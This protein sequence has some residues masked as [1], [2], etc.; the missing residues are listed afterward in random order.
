MCMI[1]QKHGSLHRIAI[2]YPTYFL[3]RRSGSNSVMSITFKH[4]RPLIFVAVI[5]FAT[6][7]FSALITPVKGEDPWSLEGQ[8]RLASE[9]ATI[10]TPSGTIIFAEIADTPAKRAH[11]LM[12]RSTLA[13]DHGMLFVFPRSAYWTFWMKNTYIALDILWIDHDGYIVHLEP[14]VPICTRQDEGCPRYHPRKQSRYV[15]E[16]PAGMTERLGLT[17]GTR[18]SIKMPSHLSSQQSSPAF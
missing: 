18:L 2:L 9:L 14:R 8:N 15:L 4:F 12:F 6:L 11:G 5:G 3:E 16:I 13:P 10:T 17:L 7:L 1:F